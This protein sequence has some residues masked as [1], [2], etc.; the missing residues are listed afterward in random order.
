MKKDFKTFSADVQ[1]IGNSGCVII[2]QMANGVKDKLYTAAHL[3][4]LRRM[5]KNDS[6]VINKAYQSLGRNYYDSLTDEEKQLPKNKVLCDII[7]KSKKRINKANILYME[8]ALGEDFN[9]ESTPDIEKELEAD[10][11]KEYTVEV[12]SDEIAQEDSF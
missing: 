5:M 11:F 12:K 1:H 8:T 4:T 2:R 9:F 6:D 10:D 3:R 7:E